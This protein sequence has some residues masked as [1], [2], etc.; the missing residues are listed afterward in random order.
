MEDRAMIA[1]LRTGNGDPGLLPRLKSSA[2]N[3]CSFKCGYIS[4][5]HPRMGV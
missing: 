3:F 2:E 5:G 1:G 4:V